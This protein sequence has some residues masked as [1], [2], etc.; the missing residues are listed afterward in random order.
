MVN[1]YLAKEVADL[2][3][4]FSAE[5]ILYALE[6]TALGLIAVFTV[7]AI[8]WAVLALFK[9]FASDN[10]KKA[11]KETKPK[12]E[13]DAAVINTPAPV[14]VPQQ[15]NGD[16][17]TVAAIIAAISAYIASDDKL[18]QEYSGGFRVVSFNRVRDKASWNTKNN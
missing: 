12:E 2:G 9:V 6:M 1:N 8:I 3:G 13:C 10:S 5:R 11:S 17:A 4:A 15:T 16:D 14:A 18:S 7:L